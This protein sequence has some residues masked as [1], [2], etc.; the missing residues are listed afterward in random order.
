MAQAAR[1]DALTVR[2]FRNIAHAEFRFAADG[3]VVLGEN[4]H[5]KSNLVESIAYLRLLRSQRGARDRDLIRHG[6]SAFHVAAELNGVATHRAIVPERVEVRARRERERDVEVPP[7]LGGRAS[8][9]IDV[10]RRERDRR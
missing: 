9:E 1:L 3:I 2:D 8:H 4:G 5:G 7:P 6:A 10:A